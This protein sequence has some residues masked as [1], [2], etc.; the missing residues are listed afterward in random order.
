MIVYVHADHTGDTSSGRSRSGFTVYLN[1]AYVYWLSKKQ[2]SIE[3]STFGSEFMTIKNVTEC[4]RGLRYILRMTGM[5]VVD[6][7]F[8]YGDNQSV[9]CNTMELYSTLKK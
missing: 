8:V 7:A 3:T 5:P 9:L 4:I 1:N 6:P 2:N